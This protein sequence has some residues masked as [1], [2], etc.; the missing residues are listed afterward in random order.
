[1]GRLF[2]NRKA[3]SGLETAIVLIA[4]VIVA[5]AFSY[6]VL[7]MG[8][9]ATQKSQQVVLGGLA[10]ASSALLIDGPAYGYSSECAPTCTS[11][12]QITTIIFWL[13]TAPGATS[14]DLN[15]GKTTISY[16]NPR[17]LWPN[18]YYCSN[19]ACAGK[20]DN[21]NL[22]TPT[23]TVTFTAGGNNYV[24]T[25][26]A[27]NMVWETGSGMMLTAGGKVRVTI[28]LSQVTSTNCPTG[29]GCV[30]GFLS[31]DEAFETI[32]KPPTG[33]FLDLQFVAPAQISQVNDL[34]LMGG[35][36][37]GATNPSLSAGGGTT[38]T[39]T[40][41]TST[42]TT[43]AST[44]SSAPTGPSS[45]IIY[46][47]PTNFIDLGCYA[48][49]GGVN[50]CS[51]GA[52]LGPWAAGSQIVL[53][54]ISPI[55]YCEGWNSCVFVSWSDGGAQTHTITVPSTPTLLTFTAYFQEVGGGIINIPIQPTGPSVYP[56]DFQQLTSTLQPFTGNLRIPLTL[57]TAFDTAGS[58]SQY[59][60]C[61]LR[62][63]PRSR[64]FLR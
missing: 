24:A 32:V 18:I 20:D 42:A 10:A 56:G 12:A 41:A 14:V 50:V 38:S 21:G 59:A 45:A 43:S 40:V 19:G 5:S 36:I 9:L 57:A 51:N 61:A 22:M 1:M 64:Q 63:S 53:S 11:S 39:T 54:A 27:T 26:A 23:G 15:P 52:T 7:N 4:F 60:T 62:E 44:T 29:P 8:F 33:S 49:V 37:G 48:V 31:T 34:T 58:V 47:S 46:E 25:G 30:S 3:I 13:K 35:N 16:E 55:Q 28:D 2:R 17:G 6:A